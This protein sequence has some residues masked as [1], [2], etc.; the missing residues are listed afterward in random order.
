[1]TESKVQGGQSLEFLRK[2]PKMR[3]KYIER[4]PEMWIIVFMHLWMRTLHMCRVKPK[5]AR[6][7][8]LLKKEQLLEIFKVNN[9]QSL[10]RYREH[11]SCSN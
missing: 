5:R 11:S 7:E 1:M 8:Q 2:R 9:A 10:Y 6:Q 4:T 3:K